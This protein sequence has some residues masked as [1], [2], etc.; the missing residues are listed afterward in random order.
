MSVSSNNNNNNSDMYFLDHFYSYEVCKE[1]YSFYQYM[2][3]HSISFLS[4]SKKEKVTLYVLEA[5]AF[6]RLIADINVNNFTNSIKILIIA[7]L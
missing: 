4:P 2:S 1:N 3:R 5:R 7:D 6:S